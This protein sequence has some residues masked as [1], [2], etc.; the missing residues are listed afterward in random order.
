MPESLEGVAAAVITVSDSVLAGRADD[1]SGPEAARLIERSG[2]RV[3]RSD[4]VP[5]DREEIS[6]LLVDLAADP[7]IGLVVTTGGTGVA[8]RD[9]T[10]EATQDVCERLVPGLADVMRRASIDKTPHGAL[11]RAVAGI[12]SRT[13]IVNLP[14]S[15]GGVSDCLGAILPILPHA[16]RL[17]RDE[18]TAHRQ[19]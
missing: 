2:G 1:R 10:P 16:L 3:V 5:D 8:P 18:T 12:R 14:G 4:T 9:V 11:S 19:T 17:I 13:L 7:E 15:T 6:S